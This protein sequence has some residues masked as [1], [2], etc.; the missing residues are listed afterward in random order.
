MCSEARRWG[1]AYCS[2]VRNATTVGSELRWLLLFLLIFITFTVIMLKFVVPHH[3]NDRI[4]IAI[5][6]LAAGIVFIGL[7]T[8]ITKRSGG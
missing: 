7:R 3:F 2:T 8:W 5:A 6:A 1:V 4:A